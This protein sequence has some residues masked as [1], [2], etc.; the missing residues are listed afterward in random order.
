M[1]P[2]VAGLHA[3]D[4]HAAARPATGAKRVYAT[5]FT[6]AEDPIAERGAWISGGTVGIDWANI[7]TA[8][9]HAYGEDGCR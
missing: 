9:G 5:S 7:A 1:L 3:G 6:A 8:P 2:L 4:R